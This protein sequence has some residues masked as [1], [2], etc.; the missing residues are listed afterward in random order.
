MRLLQALGPQRTDDGIL[1][2]PGPQRLG[3]LLW[4]WEDAVR[5]A[6]VSD[7]GIKSHAA[8]K[9]KLQAPQ[10]GL[11]IALGCLHTVFPLVFR[12][13]EFEDPLP[14]AEAFLTIPQWLARVSY[15]FSLLAN[16]GMAS[17]FIYTILRGYRIMREVARL[18]TMVWK[19]I[20]PRSPR[21]SG[22]SAQRTVSNADDAS[23][24]LQEHDPLYN[25]LPAFRQ[26]PV[27]GGATWQPDMGMTSPGSGPCYS[28]W[29]L[30]TPGAL[31]QRQEPNGGVTSCAAQCR[32]KEDQG[33]SSP[34]SKLQGLH[35]LLTHQAL[36]AEYRL[37]NADITASGAISLV[38]LVLLSI[39]SLGFYLT[40]N[41][42]PSDRN[43]P[44]LSLVDCLI[45][46]I[47]LMAISLTGMR[48]EDERHQIKTLLRN[49]RVMLS[50]TIEILGDD[51]D[52]DTLQRRNIDV[53]R[54]RRNMAELILSV[55]QDS[56]RTP[57]LSRV[58]PLS[59][60]AFIAAVVGVSVR[61]LSLVSVT[62]R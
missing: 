46:G 39:S 22:S 8:D 37:T 14:P 34:L 59:R 60:A 42:A 62:L 28:I 47:A 16:V 17:F 18:H 2:S 58:I 53:L 57:R 20:K 27:G 41:D 32:E 35:S 1:L 40:S 9:V 29:S 5:N 15:A 61:A 4:V 56:F 10:V 21:V 43:W 6:G 33:G 12:A 50:H 31:Q 25:G 24:W 13:I 44:W 36:H 55:V 51:T 38:L 30:S 45:L 23:L 49:Y 48:L 11:S 26:N 7:S 3:P 54:R 19:R 52:Q